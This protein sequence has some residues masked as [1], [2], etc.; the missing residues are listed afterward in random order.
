MH[1]IFSIISILFIITC[2]NDVRYKNQLK[3]V[4]YNSNYVKWW[5]LQYGNEKTQNMD[6]YLR[7]TEYVSKDSHNIRL[8]GK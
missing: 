3:P 8:I 5:D 7:G 4:F 6:I 2:S 1:K